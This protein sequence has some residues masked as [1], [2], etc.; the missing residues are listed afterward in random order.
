MKLFTLPL[1]LFL[2]LSSS[3][4]RA[5]ELMDILNKEEKPVIDYTEGTFKATHLVIGQSIE[6]T[7]KGNMEFLISHHFGR[8]N[9]GYQH[10]YGLDLAFIRI[11][12]E[13][14]PLNWL[15]LG[16]GLNTT[17]I[18]WDGYAKVKFLRQSTGARRMP[19]SMS[20]FA[21]MAV[22]TKAFTDL[23]RDNYTSSRMTYAFELLMARKFTKWLSIQLM[24]A[25]VHRN[26]VATST[27]HNDIFSLG[28]G[29]QVKASNRVAF[30]AEYYY[31]FPNQ[32]QQTGS[33][34]PL[35]NSFSFGVDI[36]TGGHVFQIFLTNSEG[37]IEEY[38]IPGTTG[39]WLNGDIYLG[40]TIS[41]MFTVAKQKL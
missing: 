1:F 6:N 39:D 33:L 24:P 18:T 32:I 19:L 26:L 7:P 22:S 12:T 10:I 3:P 9:S 15:A 2:V 11:G 16:V 25:M 40:F 41:R 35:H 13:Y 20:G 28:G 34:P 5:Q 36:E 37:L 17:R 4:G 29:A 27:D 21:S 8:I 31:L 30:E 23:T 14:A 38:F